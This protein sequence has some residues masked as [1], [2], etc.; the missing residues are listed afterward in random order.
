MTDYVTYLSQHSDSPYNDRWY[1]KN[2]LPQS[3]ADTLFAMNV[4]E[5]YGPYKTEQQFNLTKVVAQRQLADSVQAK[6]ILISWE[7][8][9]TAGEISRTK[10][11]AKTLADSLLNVIQRDA[12]KFEDLA[13]QFSND[14]SVAQNNGDLGY[15]TPQATVEEFDNFIF[16]NSTGDKAVVETDFGFHIISI[17]D[18]KNIQKAIKVAFITKN[19]EPSEETLNQTFTNATRFESNALKTDFMAAS[20][21]AMVD[22]KPV[23]KIGELEENIPGI[24]NNREIVNWA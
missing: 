20:K 10:E 16:N 14:P 3:I 13:G 22:V 21:E 4:G 8:L 23:N 18:Q 7:G 17:E 1:F 19:I 9:Q 6:H 15:L 11:Q 24:G 12:S 5:I 2:Q